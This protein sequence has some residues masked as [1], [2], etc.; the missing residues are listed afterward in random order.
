[1]IPLLFGC[2]GSDDSPVEVKNSAPLANPDEV[3]LYQ[4]EA[5]SIDV[6]ANDTDPDGDTLTVVKAGNLTVEDNQVLYAAGEDQPPGEISVSYTISDGTLEASSS[7]TIN[8]LEKDTELPPLSRGEFVGSKECATCHS[9]QYDEWK[10]TRHATVM[11]K[12]YTEEGHTIDAPWGT[13]DTPRVVYADYQHKYTTYMKGDEYWVTL[14]DGVDATKEVSYRIDAVGYRTQINF[15][16]YDQEK[17]SLQ[18]LPL[19]YWP[20]TGVG[21]N[22][23]WTTWLSYFWYNP[24]GSFIAEPTWS[25]Y[26]SISSYEN[27]CAECHLTAFEIDKWQQLPIGFP[28]VT[29]SNIW[30]AHWET[31]CE[32]C[33]GPGAKH[34]RSMNK[35]DI[36]NPADLTGDNKGSECSNC[37]QS[38]M[39]A[40]KPIPYA[41]E[42]PYKF[43]EENPEEKGEHFNVGDNLSDFYTYMERANWIGNGHKRGSKSHPEEIA[44]S[45][46]GEAGLTCSSCHNPHS[47]ELKLP[48]DQ[49]CSS[50]HTDK[51]NAA[52]KMTSH[53]M[54]GV[55]CIDCHMPFSKH[56]F[57]RSRRYDIRSHSFKAYSPTDSLAVYDALLPFTEEG[58]DEEQDLTKAW[59]TIQAMGNCY[60]NFAYPP[61]MK[62]CTQFD[63]MPNAC[64]SCHSS[65]FPTPGV[66]SDEE[67]NKL[68]EG[69]KRYQ[70]FLDASTQ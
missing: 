54:L 30:D 17:N 20:D 35:E 24:D 25:M 8:V 12:L 68:I 70:R 59:Q 48:G 66:F 55:E 16:S 31:G 13:E 51:D 47:Q 32:K 39:P 23:R 42:L 46:H 36:V 7:I 18:V 56:S 1:M 49:L 33:H 21:E 5:V 22:E 10:D 63:I 69:E 26:R 29:E 53:D 2:N 40:N 19:V 3:T 34:S 45:S 67:R 65:E 61:N 14:H 27:K 41:L 28:V 43:N 11:R 6:L 38:G 50:C 60:E 57:E 58:A 64:S 44:A 52:H 15:F 62:Q 4:G 9:R 37:H